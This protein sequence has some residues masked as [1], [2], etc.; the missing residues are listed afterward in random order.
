LCDQWNANRKSQAATS[1]TITATNAYGNG[2]ANISIGVTAVG[3]SQWTRL[4]GVTTK[5]TQANS[6][7]SDSSG[8]VFST[9][10]TYGNLDGQTL[11][12]TEDLF[13]VKYD[14]NG[15]KQWTRLLGVTSQATR[16]I[17][18]TSDPSGNV[19]TTGY[20]YGSLDG[21]TFSG[22]KDLFVV[23]YNTSGVKQWTRLLGIAPKLTEGYGITS[24]SSGNIYITGVTEGNL[25]GQTLGGFTGLFVVKYNSSGI[26][27][28]TRLLANSSVNGTK[29]YGITADSSGNVYATGYTSGNLDGQ[30]L[31]GNKDM[32]VVKYN[33][34]GVKQWTR[35][36]GVSLYDTGGNGIVSDVSGNLYI[37]GYTDGNLDGQT[38]IGTRDLFIAKFDSSGAKQWTR[39]LGV[40]SSST[41]ANKI[42]LDSNGYVIATGSTNGNLDGQALTGGGSGGF[43]VKY[44]ASGVKQWTR[45]LGVATGSVFGTGIA[46]DL[47]GYVYITGSSYGNLDGQTKTGI[48]DLFIVK[49][50]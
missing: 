10:L 23:K 1:Y 20:T 4:L 27:Q 17:D 3:A 21:Q 29:G 24:D 28:W 2:T 14:T 39:I 22:G 48:A 35:L 7:A 41:N 18:I 32:F 30:T 42:T 6:V 5:A 26:K 43:I 46:S 38:K 9:G 49:F 19:Y 47:T 44:N 37:A 40:N 8:N 31:T 25:D 50:Q 13:V 45:I 34:S 11:T 36:L 33:S 12:G 16:A 15:A